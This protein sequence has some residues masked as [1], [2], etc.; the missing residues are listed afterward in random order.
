MEHEHERERV[1]RPAPRPTTVA[2]PKGSP[3]AA[4]FVQPVLLHTAQQPA[5]SSSLFLGAGWSNGYGG[6]CGA[7]SRWRRGWLV[8]VAAPTPMESGS[9]PPVVVDQGAHTMKVGFA[10]EA[11]PRRRVPTCTVRDRGGRRYVGDQLSEC[12]EPVGLAA[13]HRRRRRRSQLRLRLRWERWETPPP[14]R[15]WSRWSPR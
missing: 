8:R 12:A 5:I 7:W 3:A 2:R 11:G 6:G 10:G 15:R 14:P 4:S 9:L 1:E 13:R